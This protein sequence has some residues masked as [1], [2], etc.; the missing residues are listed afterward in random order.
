[1]DLSCGAIRTKQSPSARV[2]TGIINIFLRKL[3]QTQRERLL[4]LVDNLDSFIT[5]KSSHDTH[6]TLTMTVVPVN[7]AS[8]KKVKNSVIGNPSAKKQLAQDV[9]LIQSYVRHIVSFHYAYAA[10]V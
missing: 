1:M 4:K 7:V 5:P 6:S 8:L 3:E 2:W 10:L 9:L